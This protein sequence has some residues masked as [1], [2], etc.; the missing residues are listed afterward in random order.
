MNNGKYWKSATDPQHRVLI[1][2]GT[3]MFQLQLAP[4]HV[5]DELHNCVN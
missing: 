2:R 1:T 4:T 5:Q 3:M